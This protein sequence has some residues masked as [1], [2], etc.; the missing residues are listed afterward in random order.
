M[1]DESL[2]LDLLRALRKAPGADLDRL[3]DEVGMP[4]TNFGRRVEA[5]LRRPL[6]HLLDDGLVEEGEGR[7]RLSERGRLRLAERA[8]DA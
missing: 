3:A 7:F 6:E 1:N 4:R 5:R 2:E 8:L